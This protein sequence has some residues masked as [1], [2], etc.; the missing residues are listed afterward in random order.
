MMT[1]NPARDSAVSSSA[2]DAKRVPPVPEIPLE[3]AFSG[4]CEAAAGRLDTTLGASRQNEGRA[5]FC[6]P[7]RMHL[8]SRSDRS[9]RGRTWR[10]Q[11][12]S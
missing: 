3:R 8:P 6:A 7:D 1:V 5:N 2:D 10:R 4:G 12:R 9:S 11:E